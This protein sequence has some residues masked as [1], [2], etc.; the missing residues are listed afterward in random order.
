M[1][2]RQAIHAVHTEDQQELLERL[3]L[4]DAF[5]SGDL[6]CRDC[7]RPV[8][9]YG[10]GLVQMNGDGEIKVACADAGCRPRR[11]DP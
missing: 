2:E 1:T 3:G 4:L 7:E 10:L 5:A 6:T 8:A 9:E 11:T